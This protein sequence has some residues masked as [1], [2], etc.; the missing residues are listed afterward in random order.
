MP[1]NRHISTRPLTKSDGVHIWRIA[2]DAGAL[3]LNSLYSYLL[4]CHHF[5]ETS[6]AAVS[7]SEVIGFITGYI[8]PASRETLFIWQVAVN[9][10]FRGKG[11]A[12]KMLLDLVERH[13]H[14]GITRVEATIEPSNNKSLGLFT[15]VARHLNA[16]WEYTSDL[17][18][19]SDFGPV[20]HEPERL[21]RIGPITS[22]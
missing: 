13:L 16:P 22:V 6:I 21:F 1:D 5:G 18:G 17:F 15:A 20:A 2:R 10:G 12:R 9:H 3:D 14:R 7:D 4:M 19:K 11:V 8:T